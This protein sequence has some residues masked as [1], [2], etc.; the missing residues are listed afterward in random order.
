MDV[1]S[2]RSSGAARQASDPPMGPV[3]DD[4]DNA[5]TESL[6]STYEAELLSRSW[7]MSQT[8]ARMA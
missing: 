3:C 1:M 2:S 5:M 4:Y 7:F 6:F 8:K